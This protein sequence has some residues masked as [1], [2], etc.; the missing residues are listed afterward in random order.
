MMIDFG[1][2]MGAARDGASQGSHSGVPSASGTSVATR[3]AEGLTQVT[4][5]VGVADIGSWAREF[6]VNSQ[7]PHRVVGGSQVV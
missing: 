4:G 3:Y 5:V 1:F 7:F 6:H 2:L